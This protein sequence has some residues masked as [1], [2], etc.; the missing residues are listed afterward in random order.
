MLRSEPNKLVALGQQ[1]WI[2]RDDQGVSSS[3]GH[4][5]KCCV[6]L[7]F[8]AGIKNIDLYSERSRSILHVA[9]LSWDRREFWIHQRRHF[10]SGGYELANNVQALRP[11]L[12]THDG[13]T[14]QIATRAV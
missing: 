10:G 2:G 1:E 3:L 14:G 11:H 4:D 13:C 6:N 9:H 8:S 7:R 5:S 12:Q